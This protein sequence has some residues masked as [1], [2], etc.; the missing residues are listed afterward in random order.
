M[1]LAGV[2]FQGGMMT[3][4]LRF[5]GENSVAAIPTP[6]GRGI[7]GPPGGFLGAGGGIGIKINILG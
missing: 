5:F 7:S 3:Q 6:T 1:A 4:E 2:G